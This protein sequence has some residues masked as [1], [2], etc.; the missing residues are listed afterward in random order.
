MDIRCRF[1]GEPIDADE[2]HSSDNGTWKEWITAF[3]RY[4]CPVVDALFDDDSP[5]AVTTSCKQE[6][7]LN[8]EAMI[9]IEVATELLGDDID[10]LAVTIEDAINGW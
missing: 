9:A 4:G 5:R 1:C 10:G 3:T 6:A 8:D 2:F 7:I